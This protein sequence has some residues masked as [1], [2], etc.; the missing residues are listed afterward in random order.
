MMDAMSGFARLAVA[1]L[2]GFGGMDMT[3]ATK[4]AMLRSVVFIVK[5]KP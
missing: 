5:L 1:V 2:A 3:A 4:L